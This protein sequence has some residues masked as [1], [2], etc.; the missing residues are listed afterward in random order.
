[1][2]PMLALRN[3]PPVATEGDLDPIL[4]EQLL[5]RCRPPL[6][7]EQRLMAAVL[8]DAI[9]LRRRGPRA[10]GRGASRRYAEVRRWFASGDTRWPF[11]FVNVCQALNLEPSAVRIAVQALDADRTERRLASVMWASPRSQ[12]EWPFAAAANH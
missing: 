9:N 3:R 11:S 8:E 12:Q 7:P 1:M 4:P 10:A 2:T 5:D 6:R